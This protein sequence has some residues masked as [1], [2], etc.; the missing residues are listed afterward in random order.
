MLKGI[1]SLHNISVILFKN[2]KEVN[3]LF[4][5]IVCHG[6]QLLSKDIFL[7]IF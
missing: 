2:L 4:C 7:N 6:Q 5:K 1:S 3:T